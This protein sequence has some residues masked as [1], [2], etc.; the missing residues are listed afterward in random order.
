MW[1]IRFHLL[2]TKH[3]NKIVRTCKRHGFF[4]RKIAPTVFAKACLLHCTQKTSWRALGREF[5]VDHILLY[6]FYTSASKTELLEEILHI[7]LESR[8]ALNIGE[9]KQVNISQLDNSSEIYDLTM[10]QLPSILPHM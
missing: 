6:R 1:I 4:P 7:F 5:H 2:Q 8:I 3:Y 9:A 10:Q